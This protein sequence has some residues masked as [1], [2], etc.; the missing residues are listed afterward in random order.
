M[1]VERELFK[2]LI[3][4]TIYFYIYAYK[5]IKLAGSLKRLKLIYANFKRKFKR[6]KNTK[7]CLQIGDVTCSCVVL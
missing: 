4:L 7:A 2:Y 1:C 3:I 6:N 5:N